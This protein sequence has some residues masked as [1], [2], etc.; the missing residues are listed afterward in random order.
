MEDVKEDSFIVQELMRMLLS[1]DPLEKKPTRVRTGLWTLLALY[2]IF[3]VRGYWR[4]RSNLE[5]ILLEESELW[6]ARR[7]NSYLDCE[8]PKLG[9]QSISCVG[10]EFLRPGPFESNGYRSAWTPVR[11]ALQLKTWYEILV[12]MLEDVVREENGGRWEDKSWEKTAFQAETELLTQARA[13][14]HSTLSREWSICSICRLVSVRFNFGE[15]S[16]R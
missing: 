10:D 4:P 2:T 8:A 14:R 15:Q 3:R 13:L 5:R 11:P 6:S 9:T 7:C 16:N 12:C 1:W